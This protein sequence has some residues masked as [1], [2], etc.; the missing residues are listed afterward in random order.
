MRDA[1]KLQECVC[2]CGCKRLDFENICTICKSEQCKIS[3]KLVMQDSR[4]SNL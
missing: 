1:M 4:H 3:I 2:V